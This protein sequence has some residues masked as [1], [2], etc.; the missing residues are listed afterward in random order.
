MMEWNMLLSSE[1]S[2]FNVAVNRSS[3]DAVDVS[4]DI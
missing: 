4:A 2:C 1:V 3:D